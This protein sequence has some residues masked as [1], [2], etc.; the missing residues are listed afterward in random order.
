MQGLIK[1]KICKLI[2]CGTVLNFYYS[3]NRP[4]GYIGKYIRHNWYGLCV[5]KNIL[6]NSENYKKKYIYLTNYF[7]LFKLYDF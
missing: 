1:K 3:C 5:L 4:N 6:K 2:K 7:Y